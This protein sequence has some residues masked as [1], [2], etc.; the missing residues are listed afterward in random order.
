MGTSGKLWKAK[1]FYEESSFEITF[2]NSKDINYKSLMNDIV[3]HLTSSYDENIINKRIA[4]CD[5]NNGRL[6]NDRKELLQSFNKTTQ[7]SVLDVTIIPP[8][9]DIKNEIQMENIRYCLKIDFSSDTYT[10]D[11]HSTSFLWCPSS[12]R[13]DETDW[14]IELNGIILRAKY[15]FGLKC[16][17]KEI[18][19]HYQKNIISSNA[20]YQLQPN[21]SIP[22]IGNQQSLQ[23][24]LQ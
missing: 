14:D 19:L 8:Q 2:S 21:I 5:C 7:T 16:R 3:S 22:P 1:L 24:I 18:E 9:M 4:I 20:S 6:I 10:H 12:D 11:T 13:D 23:N 17:M 15:V